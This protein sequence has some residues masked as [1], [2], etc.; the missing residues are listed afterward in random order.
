VDFVV[1]IKFD[2]ISRFARF[3]LLRRIRRIFFISMPPKALL[4]KGFAKRTL[5]NIVFKELR[6]QNLDN[7]RLRVARFGLSGPSLP[8][9]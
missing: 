1:K 8:R 4:G 7:E 6:Y 9:P 2:S 5:Q 3:D